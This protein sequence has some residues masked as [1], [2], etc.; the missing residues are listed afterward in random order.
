MR[1]GRQQWATT[2][3]L[4]LLAFLAV[5][6]FTLWVAWARRHSK[7][8]V[9][10]VLALMGLSFAWFVVSQLAV[11]RGRRKLGLTRWQY[12]NLLSGSRPVDRDELFV[13]RWTL[14]LCCATLLMVLCVLALVFTS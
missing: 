8:S 11:A 5:L 4:V 2:D 6:P 3:G 13:W 12:T 10:A 14:H 1:L 9:D 7:V